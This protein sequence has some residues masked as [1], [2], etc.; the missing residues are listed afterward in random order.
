MSTA[1]KQPVKRAS[2]VER[3]VLIAAM[4][5]GSIMLWLG[6]PLGLIY[7]V[8]K[9]VDSTQPTMGPYLVLLVGIPLGMVVIGRILGALDRRYVARTRGEAD[10]YRPAWLKSMRGEREKQSQWKILDVVMLWSVAMAGVTMGVW[11]FFFAG[12]SI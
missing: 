6:W 2:L 5:V 1:A 8:S 3:G 4:A 12:S 7:A 11:F 10:R 9:A